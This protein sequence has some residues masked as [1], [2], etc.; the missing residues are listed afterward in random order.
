MIKQIFLIS[1]LTLGF[2]SLSALS[3][4]DADL[5][6]QLQLK[7]NA[8][9][10]NCLD[11]LGQSVYDKLN[12]FRV[13]MLGEMHGTDEPANFLIG[14]AELFAKNGDSVQV[15]FEISNEQI[16]SYLLLQTDSS[17]FNSEF[18]L[19]NS[20]DGRSSIAWAN[21]IARLTKNLR[22]KIFFYDINE[23]EDFEIRDSLMYL[24]IKRKIIEHRNLRII[25]LSGNIHNMRIPY[26]EQPT[27]AYYLCNDKELNLSDKICTL[28]HYGRS[29]AMLNNTG[30][31]LELRPINRTPS[32]F[33]E[34]LNFDNYLFLYATANR[35][36]GIFFTKTVTASKPVNSEP[37]NQR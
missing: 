7:E 9:N 32:I 18:F 17:V 34:T 25:T 4:Q 15:G 21:A 20:N 27:T 19:Y 1:I 30:K 5:D 6:L 2:G 31:G 10:I 33:S 16:T 3:G 24:K 28:N 11:S 14:L 35:Y 23:S 8:V 36:N 13:I 29:G 26:K 37:K 12:D 22:V